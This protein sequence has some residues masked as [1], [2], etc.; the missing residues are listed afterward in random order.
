[1]AQDDAIQVPET[2]SES[3]ELIA[4]SIEEE[5]KWGFVTDIEADS[6]PK[7]LN[8]EI[9]R[10]ISAKKNEPEFLLN[11]RLKSFAHWQTLEEPQWPHVHYPPIDF[12][13]MIYYSAPKQKKELASLDE[14][15]QSLPILWPDFE[16][17]LQHDRLAVQFEAGKRFGIV[18]H[19]FQQVI[20]Q[21]HQL[22]AVL[23]E[24]QVPRAIPM[25][26]WD[27]VTQN[28]RLPDVS[29]R[30]SRAFTLA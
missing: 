8:E 12:Q 29:V 9:I 16:I 15:D 25:S 11:F 3:D 6:A 23:L 30:N 18:L 27:D 19:Q 4:R 28:L 14:V 2:A 7:G 5:Y 20:N 10:F 26:V 21:F 1:M 13:D 17:I 22:V 24:W